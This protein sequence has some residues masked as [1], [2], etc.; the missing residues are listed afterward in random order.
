M[1]FTSY[2]QKAIVEKVFEL[3]SDRFGSSNEELKS[4]S[5]EYHITLPRHVC[6]HLLRELTELSSIRVGRI[7]NRDHATVLYGVK[8]VNRKLEKNEEFSALYYEIKGECVNM[9]EDSVGRLQHSLERTR[10]AVSA[11]STVLLRLS[12]LEVHNSK[13]TLEEYREILA[14]AL[15]I[16]NDKTANK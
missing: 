3:V 13:N 6:F 14:G 1:K 10:E 8:R 16:I 11:T 9:V 5:R 12:S 2:N 15:R 7:F 4:K